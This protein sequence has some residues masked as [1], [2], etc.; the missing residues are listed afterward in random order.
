MG[1]RIQPLQKGQNTA[2]YGQHS[3]YEYDL[4]QNGVKHGSS[5]FI[6]TQ[7]WR[8]AAKAPASVGF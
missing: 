1:I 2:D 6:R 5:P 3:F 4:R 7:N 8:E